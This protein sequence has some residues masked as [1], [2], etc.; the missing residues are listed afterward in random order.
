M[1]VRP[2]VFALGAP[3]ALSV[4]PESAETRWVRLGALSDPRR[5]AT[6]PWR[7]LGVTWPAPAWNL[8]GDVVWGLTHQMLRSLLAALRKT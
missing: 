6:R 2:V 7:L 3:A 4:G 8:D 5:R 1:M